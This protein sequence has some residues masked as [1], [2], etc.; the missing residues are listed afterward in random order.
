[1][2]FQA[3]ESLASA[4]AAYKQAK[5]QAEADAA[6]AADGL[7]ADLN[8]KL[9]QVKAEDLANRAEIERKRLEI[10]AKSARAQLAVQNATLDRMRAAS[11]L[12][13]SQVESLPS[14]WRTRPATPCTPI[15]PKSISPMQATTILFL[16]RRWPPP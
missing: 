11:A 12:R 6:L 16:W 4:E 1:M 7:I 2:Q 13:L 9:S 10:S 3:E 14:P 8:L 15:I 5:L